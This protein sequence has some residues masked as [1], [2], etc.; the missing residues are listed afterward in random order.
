MKTL[1]IECAPR[2][3]GLIERWTGAGSADYSDRFTVAVGPGQ[4]A[5]V[6]DVVVDRFKKQPLWFRVMRTKAWSLRSLDLALADEF[7]VGSAV[8]S[9]EV[10]GRTD[11]EIVF[12]DSLRFT[13]FWFSFLLNQVSLTPVSLN[14]VEA[15]TSFRHRWR[16]TGPVLF[17]FVRPGHRRLVPQLL[18]K[19]VDRP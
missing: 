13:E 4:Y 1:A 12:H 5:T 3:H 8:G 7:A 19:M 6:D 14:T 17:V 2:A 11:D 18:A 15:S 9:W 16:L 10:V